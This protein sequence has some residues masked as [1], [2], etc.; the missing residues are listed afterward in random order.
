MNNIVKKSEQ[1]RTLSVI[2]GTAFQRSVLR[3]SNFI[4]GGIALVGMLFLPS[5]L[6]LPVLLAT[7]FILGGNIFLGATDYQTLTDLLDEFDNDL[8]VNVDLPKL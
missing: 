5:G 6:L 4:L 8:I 2:I 1:V 3:S 7:L